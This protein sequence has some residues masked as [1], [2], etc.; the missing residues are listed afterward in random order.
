MYQLTWITDHLAVGSAPMSYAELDAIRDQGVDAIINLCGEYCDLHEIEEQ[1]G[2]EVYFL[3]IPDES[4]PDMEEM[5]KGLAWLDEAIYLGKKVLVHCR[6]GIGRTGTFVTAYLL[7]R[8][9][10]LK[11]ATRKLRHTRANP[12]NYAQ[13]RL[14]RKY[15]KRE[16]VLSMREPSLESRQVVELGEFFAEYEALV[17]EVEEKIARREQTASTPLPRCGRDHH[18]CCGY[19]EVKLIEAIYVAN[20]IN[21]ALKSAE[22]TA[23]IERAVA[24]GRSLRTA[25]RDAS[26]QAT[27]PELYAA[28]GL[29]CPLSLADGCILF[30]F[31]PIRCRV[32]DVPADLLDKRLIDDVLSNLSRRVFFALSGAFP[33]PEEDLL[34][35]GHDIASGRFVQVYF[36]YLASL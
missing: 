23:C 30:P 28:A 11:V 19:F 13:W 7:R 36:H 1:N 5:E 27:L 25:A 32:H 33:D 4:A 12:T 15:G 17:A 18:R 24:V 26:D 6:H 31:R 14:L 29:R 16:G 21:R 35:T 9:L 34:F 8:G 2:F 22:R 20:R 3:P 10:G